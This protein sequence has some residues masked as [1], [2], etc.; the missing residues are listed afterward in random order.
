[1]F[2]ILMAILLGATHKIPTPRPPKI[3]CDCGSTIRPEV[4][5]NTWPSVNGF[6]NM[7]LCRCTECKQI[8]EAFL[9]L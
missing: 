3:W 7:V 6:N 9:L 8:N 1:M 2:S 5:K 4:S